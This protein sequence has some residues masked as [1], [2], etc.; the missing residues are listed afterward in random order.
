MN[1]LTSATQISDEELMAFAPSIF[2]TE[3]H[4]KRGASY[5]HVPTSLVHEKMVDAGFYPVKVVKQRARPVDHTPEAKEEALVKEAFMK[6]LVM[7]RHP[8]IYDPAGRGFYG[9]V[10]YVG[11]HA[12]RCSIQMFAG[13]LELLCGNGLIAGRV[14]EAIRLSHVRLNVMDVIEAALKMMG[15]IGVISEWRQAM[16]DTPM[17]KGAAIAMAEEALLLRWEKDKAPIYPMQLFET[18]RVGDTDSNLWGV[19][20]LLEENLRLGGQK[21]W[22]AIDRYNKA[23]DEERKLLPRPRSVTGIKA[24][25]SGLKFERDISNLADDW[26]KKAA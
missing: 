5:V 8:D 10:G 15:S 13:L 23:S 12:G 26:M 24:L 4:E 11:D 18:R 17:R 7:Y 2:K 3:K 25:D 14:A 9:Q 19:Y 21:P 16:I 1:T 22:A 20:Q 6:H